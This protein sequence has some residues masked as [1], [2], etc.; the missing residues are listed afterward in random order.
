MGPYAMLCFNGAAQEG[1]GY[2]QVTTERA[3][4]CS[5]AVAYLEPARSRLN[6][7]VVVHAQCSPS[8]PNPSAFPSL[9]ERLLCHGVASC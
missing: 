6:L 8:S 7:D 2:F 5:S 3:L 1:A 9:C 4:R